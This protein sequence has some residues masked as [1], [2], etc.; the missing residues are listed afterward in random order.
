MFWI[1]AAILLSIACVASIS[2]QAEIRY[3]NAES[4]WTLVS[5]NVEY[6]LHKESDRVTFE[7]FGPAAHQAWTPVS[8]TQN[9]AAARRDIDGQVE[10]EEIT[11]SQLKL[12]SEKTVFVKP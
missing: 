2:T 6:I 8:N 4:R 1:R 7:Y 12:V 3:S 5:G 11:P 9:V 10:G